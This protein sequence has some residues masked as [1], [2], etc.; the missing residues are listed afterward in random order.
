MSSFASKEAIPPLPAA[1]V[2]T[3]LFILSQTSSIRCTNALIRLLV[4]AG[5][6]SARR[7]FHFS[8]LKLN[9]LRASRGSDFS[10]TVSEKSLSAKLWKPL[11]STSLIRPG[12]RIIS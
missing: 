7:F 10:S 1:C 12:S 8:P 2:F 11:L 6:I 9:G 3:Y 4:K 5:V